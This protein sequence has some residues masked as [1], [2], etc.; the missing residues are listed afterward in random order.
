MTIINRERKL[1]YIS[2][3]SNMEL[4]EE[5]GSKFKFFHPVNKK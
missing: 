5:I 3:S 1:Q 4:E 2:R